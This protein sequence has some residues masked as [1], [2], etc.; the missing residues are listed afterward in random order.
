MKQPIDII[1]WDHNLTELIVYAAGQVAMTITFNAAD[2]ER[3]LI[4]NGHDNFPTM[5]WE[6]KYIWPRSFQFDELQI[7]QFVAEVMPGFSVIVN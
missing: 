7:K 4:V 5:S 6:Q 2:F 3:W 1:G